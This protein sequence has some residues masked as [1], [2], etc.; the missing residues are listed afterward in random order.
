MD[1]TILEA[2]DRPGYP[3]SRVALNVRVPPELRRELKV[4]AA[5]Q[6]IPLH[7]LVIRLLVA[8]LAEHR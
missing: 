7:V 6:D 4:V 1:V 8:G 2:R 5:E 3:D